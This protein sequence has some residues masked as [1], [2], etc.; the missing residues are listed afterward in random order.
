MKKF[1]HVEL[2][3]V[4]F[5]K[6]HYVLSRMTMENY[7]WGTSV[8]LLGQSNPL[9]SLFIRIKVEY[10]LNSS[11]KKAHIWLIAS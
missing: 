7:G 1:L 8:Q 10:A 9:K 3:S 6:P 4:L 11:Q 2:N 5:R